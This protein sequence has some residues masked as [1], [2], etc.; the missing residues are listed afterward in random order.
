MKIG[1]ISDTHGL[2]RPA[3]FEHFEGVEHILHAG[4]VG[5]VDVLVELETIAPVTAVWGNTDDFEI[6]TRVPERAELELGGRRI[7]VV[8]G[9]RFGSPTPELLRGAEPDADIIV[10]GHTHKP[11]IDRAGERL[12]VNPGAAG[13]PRFGLAPSIARLTLAEDHDDVEFIELRVD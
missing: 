6:R 2:L 13:P 10:Y 5:T 3:V 7:V 1:L 9:H 11:R 4:D 12:V 8:H